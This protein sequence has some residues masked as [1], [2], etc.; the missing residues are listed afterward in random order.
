M[1]G[2]FIMEENKEY[3]PFLPVNPNRCAICNF[4]QKSFLNGNSKNGTCTK[5]DFVY[6]KNDVTQKVEIQTPRWGLCDNF[7]IRAN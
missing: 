4:W 2:A 1:L 7:Q 6:A 3:P 5:I